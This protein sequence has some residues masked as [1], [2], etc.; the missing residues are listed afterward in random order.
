[1]WQRFTQDA[2]NVVFFA[3][4]EAQRFGE[5]FVSTEH[6][7]LGLL[8]ESGCKGCRI[9]QALGLSLERIRVEV[10]NQLP[11][12]DVRPSPD[13]TLTPRAKR[14]IDLAYSEARQ[15]GH[16][17]IGTEHLFLG[18]V[19]E[20]DG[21]AGRCLSKL[22]ADIEEARAAMAKLS[23]SALEVPFRQDKATRS[24]S[25]APHAITGPAF[26]MG[27]SIQE[28]L[29]LALLATEGLALEVIRAQVHDIGALQ[30]SMWQ[31]IVRYA[32]NGPKGVYPGIIPAV[33]EAASKEANGQ[34]IEP[35]HLLLALLD[36]RWK[37]FRFGFLLAEAGLTLERS[38][39]LVAELSS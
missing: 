14:V 19:A 38:R 30:W 2:R 10:E 37:E 23:P 29:I 18:L 15:A 3:Q 36:P 28:H 33:L 27:A 25:D 9:I 13:M 22:G 34:P 16:D 6:L 26:L 11:K 24:P 39:E 1:M 4:E 31:E 35:I 12:G 17:Y 21:L 32:R 7:L 8:R 20:S 5:G